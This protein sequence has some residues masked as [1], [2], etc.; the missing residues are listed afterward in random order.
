MPPAIVFF[1]QLEAI[2]PIRGAD[3]GSGGGGYTNVV[4]DTCSGTSGAD[5]HAASKTMK[6]IATRF[7][8][9]VIRLSFT[10]I[11]LISCSHGRREQILSDPCR[12]V[13]ASLF[14]WIF[15]GEFPA[16]IKSLLAR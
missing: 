14:F 10:T 8:L 1:D 16:T 15:A 12:F 11:D 2:A 3:A 7:R 5:T 13:S 6:I 4:L 9:H